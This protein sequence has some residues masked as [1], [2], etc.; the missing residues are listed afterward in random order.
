MIGDVI[1]YLR[2]KFDIYEILEF[3]RLNGLDL[4]QVD[5]LFQNKKSLIKKPI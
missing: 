2:D 1:E 3:H 4:I 5:I